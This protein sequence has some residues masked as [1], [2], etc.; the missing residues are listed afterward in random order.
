MRT[1]AEQVLT[2]CRHYWQHRPHA[3]SPRQT[4]AATSVRVLLA[5]DFTGYW[6]LVK[7]EGMDDFLRSVG[8]PWVVRKAAL[9][10]GGAGVDV[11]SHY[12]GG[13]L[14][15]VT[16]L[17]AKGSWSRQY[18]VDREVVQPNA[19]GTPCKTSSW[20]EGARCLPACRLPEVVGLLAQAAQLGYSSLQLDTAHSVLPD[21]LQN[22][23]SLPQP[24][25]PPSLQAGY[26]AAA[27]KAQ[28]WGWCSR[29]GTCAAT[30]WR[31]ARSCARRGAAPRQSC[32]GSTTGWRRC[33]AMWHAAVAPCCSK[34]SLVSG[35][36]ERSW[37]P[38][39][40]ERA[41]DA[42][43]WVSLPLLTCRVTRHFPPHQPPQPAACAPLHSLLL[44]TRH[45]QP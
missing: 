32:G 36:R 30:A 3:P 35:W 15:R 17:N 13:S 42:W 39:L 18:D 44:H 28:S 24:H 45:T 31:Y 25:L 6:A 12:G 20:W 29:G 43:L 11:I 1:A 9:K 10:F 33:S 26:S 22:S 5:A 37:A 14:M 23:L 8:F 34:L 40:W 41:L 7:H 16:S 19:E 27:W 2:A 21:L 38:R 4:S